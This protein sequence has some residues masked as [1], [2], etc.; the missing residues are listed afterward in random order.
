MILG[1][2]PAA[3]G[4]RH[5]GPLTHILAGQVAREGE[6]KH[7]ATVS[8]FTQSGTSSPRGGDSHTQGGSS[9]LSGNVLLGTPRVCL[10]GHTEHEDAPSPVASS[11]S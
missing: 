3:C 11:L 4:S 7:L 6:R 5:V 9:F 1:V 10:L 8:L 2:Q